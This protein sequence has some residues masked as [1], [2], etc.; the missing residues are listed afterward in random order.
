MFHADNAYSLGRACVVGNR[1]KT[2]M[3][4][5]TAFRGFGGPQGMIVIEK[6]MQDLALQV[7][8]DALDVR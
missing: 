6:A 8:Q 2:D 7:G 4:S 3:V 1:L 5:H